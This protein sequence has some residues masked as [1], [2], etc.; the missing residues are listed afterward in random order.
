[1]QYIL[2][3]S[4]IQDKRYPPAAF[5]YNN[6]NTKLQ[7]FPVHQ[8]CIDLASSNSFKNIG[9]GWPSERREMFPAPP[10]PNALFSLLAPLEANKIPGPFS[11]PL[12]LQFHA[13]TQKLCIS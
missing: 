8:I 5:C 6:K 2:R 1:M 4:H 13:F 9:G 7:T 3:Q 10:A 11:R 12:A